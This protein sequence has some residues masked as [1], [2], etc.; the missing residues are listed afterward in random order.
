[1]DPVSRAKLLESSPDLATA[2]ATAAA[3][4]DTAAPAADERVDLHFVAFVKSPQGH[5]WELDGSR[6]GPLNRGSLP[7]GEDLLGER[8]IKLGPQR[9]L[10]AEKAAG[11]AGELRFSILALGPSFG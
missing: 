9:F 10:D 6:K 8:A 11:E 7:E 5:L 4:G 3:G 1:M 2:H